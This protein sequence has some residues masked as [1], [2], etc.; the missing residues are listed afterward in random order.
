MNFR[1]IIGLLVLSFFAGCTWTTSSPP[2]HYYLLP[3]QP[4]PSAKFPEIH[5]N[6]GVE[7]IKLPR[8]LDRPQIV[9][10]K[11]RG[12]VRLAEFHRWAEPVRDGFT[13][14]LMAGLNARIPNGQVLSLPARHIPIDW[15]VAIQVTQFHVHDGHCLLQAAWRLRQGQKAYKIHREQIQVPVSNAHNYPVVVTAMSRAIDQLADKIARHLEHHRLRAMSIA[16][17]RQIP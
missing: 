6:I 9:T 7:P 5:W 8:Y 12:Q 10:V 11:D 15:A 4:P 2:A 16:S 3:A 1:L 17:E 14:V 13:R